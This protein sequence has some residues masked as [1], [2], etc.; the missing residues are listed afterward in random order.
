MY[1]KKLKNKRNKKQ[2]KQL[3]KFCRCNKKV[4]K[5]IVLCN[6]FKILTLPNFKYKQVEARKAK[7]SFA[8]KG[9]QASLVCHSF[10]QAKFLLYI[11]P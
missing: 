11:S 7:V 4:V 8:Q 10:S 5:T 3:Q 2:K 9:R 1:V 6:G